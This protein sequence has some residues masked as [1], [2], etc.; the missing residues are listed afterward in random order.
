MRTKSALSTAS[1][2]AVGLAGATLFSL[3]HAGGWTTVTPTASPFQYN[4]NVIYYTPS[5]ALDV[6]AYDG[7]LAPQSPAN[8]AS[9]INT[10]FGLTGANAVGAAVSLC[11]EATTGCVNASGAVLS[12]GVYTN[13]FTSDA[14][15]NYL[16]VHYGQGELIFHW[17]APVMP[18][19]AFAIGGVPNDVSNF[20]AYLAPVPEPSSYA[21]MLGGLVL[22]GFMTRLRRR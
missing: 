3:A 15:Y 13:S 6:I 22:L 9:I 18:G 2:I 8:I 14:A 10:Q 4:G 20:R 19:T 1:K 21:L 7:S 16:A 11:A 12:G 17:N 5:A